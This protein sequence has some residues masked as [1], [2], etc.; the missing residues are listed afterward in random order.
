MDEALK[1]PIGRFK[2]PT[3][4]TSNQIENWIS[5]IDKLPN[6]LRE[7]TL[8][9]SSYK[10]N[11]PYREGGWNGRQVVHHIADSHM[12]SIIRFKLALTE[13]NPLIKPYYED[14][15]AQLSDYNGS[16][17]LALNLVDSIHAKWVY[18]LK[19]MDDQDFTKTFQHPE[20]NRQWTLGE[21]TAL[22]AWH[23]LHHLGH[24]SIIH[25]LS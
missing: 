10:L 17:D 7:M 25:N 24:L 4:I 16:L 19:N 8:S 12:N 22:Y 23:G 6:S 2:N 11:L 18:L 21:A 9:L 15:W 13:Q 3:G 1:F 20:S 5:E 14:R